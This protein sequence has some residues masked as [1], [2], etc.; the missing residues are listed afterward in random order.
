MLWGQGAQ[1]ARK[2]RARW[3]ALTSEEHHEGFRPEQH[4]LVEGFQRAFAANSVAEKDGHKVDDF[5]VPETTTGKADTLRDGV[6]D[7]LLAQ[8]RNDEN[9]F[10]KLGQRQW[11]CLRRGL[12]ADGRIRDAGHWSS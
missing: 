8:V 7:S 12:D 3:Q 5:V 4:R 1:K 10:S 11:G 6:K 2:R 9:D